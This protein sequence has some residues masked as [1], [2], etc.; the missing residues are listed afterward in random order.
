M[1]AKG[2]KYASHY[3]AVLHLLN[4]PKVFLVSLLELFLLYPRPWLDLKYSF[5]ISNCI[6]EKKNN[7]NNL[8]NAFL[9]CQ[10]LPQLCEKKVSKYCT[11]LNSSLL[12]VV[13]VSFKAKGRLSL[14]GFHICITWAF[15]FHPK[16]VQKKSPLILVTMLKI[17]HVSVAAL[18]ESVH[19]L[20]ILSNRG[21]D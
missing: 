17:F 5:W 12:P 16:V 21:F 11:C 4:L 8:D 19:L 15:S 6:W 14:W 9:C 18:L 1:F 10:S 13:G 7:N 3:R 2:K 20:I